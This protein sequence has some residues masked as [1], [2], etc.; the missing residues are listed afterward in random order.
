LR[1]EEL[2]AQAEALAQSTEWDA[3]AAELK[4]L[5]AEWK[6]V[7]PVRRNKAEGV[8]QRFRVACDAFFERYKNRDALALAA[9]RAERE[10]LCLEL[11]ALVAS[12]GQEGLLQ[13]TQTLQARW[14]QAP[15]LGKDDELSLEKRFSEARTRLL[16][17]H[18]E[19][20]RGTDLDPDVIRARKQRLLERLEAVLASAPDAETLSGEDLARRL[21]EALAGNTIG[22]AARSEAQRK[23][24]L[25]EAEAARSAWSKLPAL[26]GDAG[27]ALEQRF[28]D[29]CARFF[30]ERAPKALPRS[31]SVSSRAKPAR[32]SRASRTP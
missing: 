23:A 22:G 30:S 11:E 27:E 16:E 6:S 14:R 2:C 15:R 24:E 26:A 12:E 19:A 4:R 21:M 28:R 13:Q 10:A 32:T 1:K 31:G 7:G 18:A 9:K 17:I 8:W 20:F 3:S 25:E 5:Q 29:A